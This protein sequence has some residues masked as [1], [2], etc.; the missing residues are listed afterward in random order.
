MKRN[1][2][3]STNGKG[4]RLTMTLD[5]EKVAFTRGET[6]YEVAERHRKDIPTLCYDPRLEPFGGCRLC[7]VELEGAR[8]P[9]ASCTM[10]AQ[11]GM[12]VRTRTAALETQRR[13][14]MEMV[15]SEN[16]DTDV[17]P[18]HGYASQEM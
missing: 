1:G 14:L 3:P 12:R 6:I 13:I 5:G 8:N 4:V 10:E 11:P 15:A 17:D 2:S 18:M 16:R 7:V 9:V